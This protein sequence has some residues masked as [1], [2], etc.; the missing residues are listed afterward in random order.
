MKKTKVLSIALIAAIGIMLSGCKHNSGSDEK[1]SDVKNISINLKNTSYL[2]TQWVDAGSG[3]SAARAADDDES[4][5][6]AITTDNKVITDIIK[7][8]DELKDD[9]FLP[10]VRE[11]YRCDNGS[12]EVK[13]TYIVFKWYTN[14]LKYKDD[15]DA[16]PIGQVLFVSDNGKVYDIFNKDGDVLRL[17]ATGKK[18]W[19]GKEYIKFDSHGNAFIVGYEY[20]DGYEKQKI[21]YWDASNK[22][23]K[24][25]G[26]ADKSEFKILDF[27]ITA[28]GEWVF[29]NANT[30][31]GNSGIYG[32]DIL[33]GGKAVPFYE[34]S[35]LQKGK[36]PI[37]SLTVDNLD[38]LLFSLNGYYTPGRADAGIYIVT[39]NSKG[40]SKDTMKRYYKLL[41]AD[42]NNYIAS[43]LEGEAYTAEWESYKNV[44]VSVERCKDKI[45]YTKF[46][47]YLRTCCNAKDA[48]FSLAYFKNK[49]A[50]ETIT[51]EGTADFTKLYKA[52]ENGNPLKNEAAL[53]YLFETK[54]DWGA[55]A[56]SDNLFMNEFMAFCHTAKE[57]VEN[58]NILYNLFVDANNEKVF[59]P[60]EMQYFK[61]AS[62]IN[63]KDDQFE[64]AQ[65][66]SNDFGM[67][68]FSDIGKLQDNGKIINIHSRLYNITSIDGS[69]TTKPYPGNLGD[70]NVKFYPSYDGTEREEGD[71]WK[72][73]PYQA[74]SKGIGLLS[75]DQKTIYYQTGDKTE[76]LLANDPNKGDISLIYSFS[77]DEN[78]LIYN[79]VKPNGGVM[80]VSI[81][82]ATKTATKL[83]LEKKLESM[84]KM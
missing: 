14:W 9:S 17:A 83:P 10:P 24:S 74:N 79:A 81:D 82:L 59:T 12:D 63:A 29:V 60:S 21:Y 13:G 73:L 15:S 33:N 48:D 40:Y 76:D 26:M 47:N 44:V 7:L 35:E 34:S 75:S 66:I 52:D 3:R 37:K 39:K 1:K 18:E 30:G 31:D 80:M 54:S 56:A 42:M 67:W 69:F 20:E 70:V 61:I 19:E 49:T 32:F 45:N 25:F 27:D 4:S 28:G 50:L 11:V 8:S 78:T 6:I 38:R 5:L 51:D 71:P 72:K 53:K 77:L 55:E 2:A 84:I 64:N 57:I 58:G 46:L 16:E 36:W 41:W 22:I 68:G 23:L 65:F 62:E 43:E